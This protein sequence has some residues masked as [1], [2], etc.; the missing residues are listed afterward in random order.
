MYSSSKLYGFAAPEG[1]D[2]Q[3]FF[4][5]E[6]FRPL[7]IT[8]SEPPPLVGEM[9]EVEYVLGSGTGGQAPRAG[10]VTRTEKPEQLRGVVESFG[11]QR[12]WGFIKSDGG[13]P[14]Y[15]HRSEVEE[16]RLP[17]PGRRVSFFRGFR[18]GRPRACYVRLED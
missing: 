17:L 16:G 5:V 18:Q 12:G 3:V 13:E 10:K 15:L 14:F 9:V 7:D 2:D 11:E 1:T 6:V 8:A 4:H